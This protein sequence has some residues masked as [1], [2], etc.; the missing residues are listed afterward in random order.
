VERLALG[1]QRALRSGEAGQGR[2]RQAHVLV[3]A[4]SRGLPEHHPFQATLLSAA[5]MVVPAPLVELLAAGGRLVQ[6]IGPCGR[7]R[8]MLFAEHARRLRRKAVLMSAHFVRLVGAH[9][10]ETE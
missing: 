9:G 3:G 7:E 5:F 6:R 1:R 4:G 2:D 10:F 8:V